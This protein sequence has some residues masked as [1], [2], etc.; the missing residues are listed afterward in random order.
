MSPSR[1]GT[2][3]TCQSWARPTTRQAPNAPDS[4]KCAPRVA[5]AI[6]LAAA[7]G[8]PSSATSTS[9]VAR[10]SS[11]SRTTPPTSH[12]CSPASASRIASMGGPVM[13]G[14]PSRW[15]SRGTRAVMP[16]VTS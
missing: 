1:S 4:W 6:R 2:R 12:A 16:Q 5:R 14:A 8:S 10:P 13:P 7:R 11:R 3:S 15:Y 9:S